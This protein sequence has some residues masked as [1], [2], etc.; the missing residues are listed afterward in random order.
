MCIVR[1]LNIQIKH[2]GVES[3]LEFTF[4]GRSYATEPVAYTIIDI[5]VTSELKPKSHPHLTIPGLN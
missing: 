5:F 3:P 2:N 1:L 4:G